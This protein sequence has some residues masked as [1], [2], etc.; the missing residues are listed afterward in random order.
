MISVETSD[1]SWTK[2]T[3]DMTRNESS[4]YVPKSAKFQGLSKFVHVPNPNKTRAGVPTHHILYYENFIYLTM[5]PRSTSGAPRC[6][7][8]PSALTLTS[9]RSGVSQRYGTAFL[10]HCTLETYVM[11]S[12]LGKPLNTIPSSL[13]LRMR[14]A[15][16]ILAFNDI[17]FV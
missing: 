13:S 4:A 9:P 2:R 1:E 15:C 5:R 12:G 11:S 6:P 10:A 7:S 14:L 3:W 17:K 8:S 16:H